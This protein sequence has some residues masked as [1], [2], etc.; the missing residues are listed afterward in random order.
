[1]NLETPWRTPSCHPLTTPC[2]LSKSTALNFAHRVPGPGQKAVHLQVLAWLISCQQVI[3]LSFK[4][5]FMII[6][7]NMADGRIA[8]FWGYRLKSLL[9]FPHD[10]FL[11][12]LTLL[13]SEICPEFSY[14]FHPFQRF[15]TSNTAVKSVYLSTKC[16]LLSW[17][18][19]LWLEIVL[20]LLIILHE[21]ILVTTHPHLKKKKDTRAT[22]TFQF[23]LALKLK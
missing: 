4:Y 2:S 7:V 11:S 15:I 17:K 5:K 19:Q 1:M 23:L 13:P 16:A 9:W 18:T 12:L 21:F 10:C 8:K 22:W 20:C 6:S 14:L 3:L